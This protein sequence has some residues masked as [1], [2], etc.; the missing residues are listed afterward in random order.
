MQRNRTGI[1]IGLVLALALCGA[2]A[3][4]DTVKIGVVG[5]RTG[6][7]AAT[8]AAFDEGIKL[9]VDYVNGK[10]GVL[11][12]K[13]EVAFED[14]AGAPDKA[15]SGFERLVTRDKV[16]MVLGE[17]HSSS[18]LAQIEVAN[19]LKVPFVVVE[20]W[21][22]EI[23]AKN[24][25]YV[26]RAGPSNSGVVNETIAQWVKAEN[27]KRAYVI[28]E[29][30]DWGI[31]IGK[32]TENA[33]AKAGIPYE[34]MITE[35]N[36][37]DHYVELTKI[38]A[39]KPDVVLAYIY[40]VGLH[41]FVAQAGETGVSPKAVVLDG[42]G[43][44]S[45]W[46][47]YWKNVGEYGDLEC[48]VSS[49]HEKVELTPLAKHFRE[50]YTKKFGKAP[51]DY[52]SRSIFDGILIAADAINRAKSTDAEKLVEA[53]EK[54]NLETTRGTAKFGLT[55]GGPEYHQWMPPM[56]V[57]QWQNKQQ[58]VLYPTQAATGKLKR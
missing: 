26:F 58:V 12:K 18:A 24:Y 15:A 21:A 6:P 39:F 13:L 16:V 3:A 31:G 32:L 44:P 53:L 36:S 48:F 33:L 52:K 29:N 27:F 47:D 50:A 25:R 20:A 49:M 34:S 17:S 57:I 4:Q 30:T 55:K 11:G 46:P 51:T 37:Q 19:R 14:T 8:G 10:G 45:L 9:A 42:A 23:T 43:P 35:R 38:K 28:A 56:L 2:A 22:D 54:T 40:G 41:Y 5:P 7:A 1:A